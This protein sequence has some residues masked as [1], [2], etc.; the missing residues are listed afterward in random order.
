MSGAEKKEKTVSSG[1]KRV[2][3]CYNPEEDRKEAVSVMDLAEMESNG[4]LVISAIC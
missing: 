3:L 1:F 4:N 2:F